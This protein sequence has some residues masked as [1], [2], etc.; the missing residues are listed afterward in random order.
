MYKCFKSLEPRA[1]S[2]GAVAGIGRVIILLL[3]FF[4][5]R[6]VLTDLDKNDAVSLL[7]PSILP[8]DHLRGANR[9]NA[10]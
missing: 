1:V 7:D 9:K 4:A 8:N 10:Q 2:A 5:T 3:I 6:P